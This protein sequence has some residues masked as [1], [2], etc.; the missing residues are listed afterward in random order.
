MQPADEDPWSNPRPGYPWMPATALTNP[1]DV[2]RGVRHYWATQ[3]SGLP[4]DFVFPLFVERLFGS[5]AHVPGKYEGADLVSAPSMWYFENIGGVGRLLDYIRALAPQLARPDFYSPHSI[6][7]VVRIYSSAYAEARNRIFRVPEPDDRIRGEHTV[8]IVGVTEGQFQFIHNWDNWEHVWSM[9]EEY[10]LREFIEGSYIGPLRGDGVDA[11]DFSAPPHT[12]P[13]PDAQLTNYAVGPPH[14]QVQIHCQ[15][16][17][18]PFGDSREYQ[19][20]ASSGGET[21][22]II[23]WAFFRFDGQRMVCHELF[24]H[25]LLRQLGVAKALVGVAAFHMNNCGLRA[26]WFRRTRA[27][28]AVV[29]HAEHPPPLPSFLQGHWERVIEPSGSG[30]TIHETKKCS[31]V[32]LLKAAVQPHSRAAV[33]S[34]GAVGL[35]DFAVLAEGEGPQPPT[36]PHVVL[37][38]SKIRRPRR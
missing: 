19:F 11:L 23:G 20:L 28:I 2:P 9:P 4:G 12:P 3:S 17:V 6:R 32:M 8:T 31:T 24:V 25:P 16:G 27:D 15:A 13:V 14:G 21:A 29:E 36:G 34:R 35:A 10:V 7:L 37:D 1:E 38:P 18:S 30:T 22:A 33:Q 26:I 5:M